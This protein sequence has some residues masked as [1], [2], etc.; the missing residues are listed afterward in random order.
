MLFEDR[1][2]QNALSAFAGTIAFSNVGILDL[3]TEPHCDTGRM[4]S[5]LGTI[6][7][8]AMV[9]AALLPWICCLTVL[10]G[11]RIS[12]T[13]SAGP[14]LRPLGIMQ[15]SRCSVDKGGFS[16]QPRQSLW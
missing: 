5:V 11:G 14:L 10:V 12:S 15:I 7:V 4:F 9:R 8:V 1:I 6:L 16:L 2:S 13:A 3:P